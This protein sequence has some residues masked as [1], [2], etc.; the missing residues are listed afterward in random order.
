MG[1]EEC[2]NGRDIVKW[3]LSN[4]EREL[5]DSSEMVEAEVDASAVLV[6]C[7]LCCCCRC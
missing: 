6:L 2:G 7:C 3:W 5:E 1:L 4:I